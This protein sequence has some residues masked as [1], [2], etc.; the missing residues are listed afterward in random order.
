[1]CS[2][3]S[4]WYLHTMGFRQFDLFGYDSSMEEPTDDIKKETTGADDEEPR[5]KYF[6]VAVKDKRLLD[7][8]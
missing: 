1:M 2:Y 3:E 4:Y 6:K 8:W 5:P 7:Y